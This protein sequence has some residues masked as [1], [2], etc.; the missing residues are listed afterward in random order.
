MHTY[1]DTYKALPPGLKGAN[2]LTWAHSILPYIEQVAL[3]A[4]I[5]HGRNVGGSYTGTTSQRFD[6]IWPATGATVATYEYDNIAPFRPEYN[7]P[8]FH[9]PSDNPGQQ[10]PSNDTVA[11]FQNKT[12]TN[13]AVCAGNSALYYTDNL[14]YEPSFWTTSF[15]GPYNT[16]PIIG[17]KALFS[18]HN[19]AG[20]RG[21]YCNFSIA[22]DGL[23]NTVMLAEIRKGGTCASGTNMRQDTRGLMLRPGAGGAFMT[24]YT[25]PNSPQDD[26]GFYITCRCCNEP[27]RGLPC[28]D[29]AFM[30]TGNNSE[31]DLGWSA[32]RSNHTGGVNA[33]HGDGSVSFK[34]STI[35]IDVW[36]AI[37]SAAGGES[38]SE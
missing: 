12:L 13:Y 26:K 10:A 17:G 24:N 37:G 29:Y 30:G 34:S 14:P 1:H 16:T 35:N 2:G 5:S 4:K 32:A 15:V 8:G 6:F 11:A 27:T 33:A 18:G 25:A 38:L 9:C 21:T 19:Q 31:G 3:G 7:I 22:S 28:R 36:R 20:T 23:S